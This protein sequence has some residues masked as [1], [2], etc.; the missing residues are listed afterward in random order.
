MKPDIKIKEISE[1]P[2][3]TIRESATMASIPVRIGKI[4]S[5]IITFMSKKGIAP[6]GAPFAYWHNMNSESMNKGLFDMEC[7]FP[8][9]A[10]V[11][12]EGQIKASKLP[13]GKVA[14]AMHI[15]PY[16]T[17]VE[18][19]EAMQSWTKEKGYQV[20]DDMW[21]AYLTNPCEVPDKSKWM[22]EIFLPIKQSKT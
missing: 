11:E 14:T 18:T 4:Y 21:E 7:G 6:A 10:P 2:T 20:E 17:L 22:T 8:V 19:Y 3:I 5:E 9:G 16:E 15:G 13:G 1:R 12:G